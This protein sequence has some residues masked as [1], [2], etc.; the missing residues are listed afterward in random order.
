MT[1]ISYLTILAVGYLLGRLN[2]RGL[3]AYCFQRFAERADKLLVA[4][5][6]DLPATTIL[7]IAGRTPVKADRQWAKAGHYL[8]HTGHGMESQYLTTYARFLMGRHADVLPLNRAT[9]KTAYTAHTP[10]GQPYQRFRSERSWHLAL[11]YT[12]F[13]Y[14]AFLLASP[15]ESKIGLTEVAA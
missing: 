3:A 12:G 6:D 5:A 9:T 10:S 11:E 7:P 2:A 1:L 14:G 8:V 15:C 4:L 13:V